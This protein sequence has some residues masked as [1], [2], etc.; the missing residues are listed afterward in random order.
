MTIRLVLGLLACLL[1]GCD[2][3]PLPVATGPVR[4]LNAGH[5]VPGSGDLD[6]PASPATR[7]GA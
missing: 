4:P 3:R 1:S 5:W 2:A 7:A 6:L